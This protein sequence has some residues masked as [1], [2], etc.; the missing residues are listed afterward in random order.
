MAPSPFPVT[1]LGESG[2]GKELLCGVRLTDSGRGPGHQSRLTAID[3]EGEVIQII[4]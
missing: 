3:P 1:V 4:P 2:T